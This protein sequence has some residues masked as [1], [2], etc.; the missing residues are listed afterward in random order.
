[1]QTQ[2][3][4]PRLTSTGVKVLL[5]ILA[6]HPLW[7]ATGDTGL[8][9]TD[10]PDDRGVLVE[11]IVTDGRTNAVDLIV[12]ASRSAAD[13]GLRVSMAPTSLSLHPSRI[14]TRSPS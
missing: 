1:M 11:A 13:A 12:A 7:R 5:A 4:P 9:I 2:A 8:R 6:G 3:P 10:L 14:L